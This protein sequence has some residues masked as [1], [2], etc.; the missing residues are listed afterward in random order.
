MER[1]SKLDHI[2]A[3]TR[4]VQ[5]DLRQ[6]RRVVSGEQGSRARGSRARFLESASGIE[7]AMV[8]EPA[9]FR[10]AC[11]T[12]RLAIYWGYQGARASPRGY[13]ST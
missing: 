7:T 1:D 4:V 12:G 8:T 6:W 2:Q 5:K 11:R 3:G 10:S 13:P 9:C